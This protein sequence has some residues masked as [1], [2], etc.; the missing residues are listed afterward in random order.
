MASGRSLS[1]SLSH[2]H[3][4]SLTLS[5]SLSTTPSLPLSMGLEALGWLKVLSRDGPRELIEKHSMTQQ[6]H[7][8]AACVDLVVGITGGAG[9][10]A[11]LAQPGLQGSAGACGLDGP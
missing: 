4:V 2:T 7:T 10:N 6:R 8:H 9:R 1:L 3:T 5:L 11:D